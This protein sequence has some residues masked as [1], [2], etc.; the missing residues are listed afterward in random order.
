MALQCARQRG[1]IDI[2]VAVAVTAD[3]AGDAKKR[4]QCDGRAGVARCQFARGVLVQARQ[5]FEKGVAEER[6]TVLD[7]IGDGEARRAQHA[8]LPDRQHARFQARVNFGALVWCETAL[9]ARRHELRDVEFGI[10]NAFALHFGGMG[11]EHRHQTRVGE[12]RG[13]LLRRHARSGEAVE[14]VRQRAGLGRGAG[15][16]VG[17]G[18]AA[19][20][21]VFRNV[22][23]V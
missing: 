12:K 4:R 13:H 8:G 19:V 6:Q 17:A 11:G 7:F 5:L 2:G 18:A 16:Q 1:G 20:M 15:D 3:P 14:R 23:Q 21:A 10:E 22:G 9:V